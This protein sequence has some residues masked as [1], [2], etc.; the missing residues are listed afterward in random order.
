MA[1]E[2]QLP[3]QFMGPNKVPIG[4]FEVSMNLRDSSKSLK[5]LKN[6]FQSRTM[7]LTDLTT[8]GKAVGAT[9]LSIEVE[10]ED[11]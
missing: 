2:S 6:R 7:A 11:R 3:A 9:V 8:F 5:P 10:V 4:R 1:K